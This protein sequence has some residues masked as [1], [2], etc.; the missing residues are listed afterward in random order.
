[1]AVAVFNFVFKDGIKWWKSNKSNNKIG[2]KN[3]TLT[4]DLQDMTG[5]AFPPMLRWCNIQIVYRNSLESYWW[6]CQTHTKV[7]RKW[8]PNLG[9][10]WVWVWVWMHFIVADS[11][12]SPWILWWSPAESH[13]NIYDHSAVGY[14][15][16]AH[17]IVLLYSVGNKITTTIHYTWRMM[18]SNE[19]RFRVTDPLCGN[20]PVTDEFPAKGQWRGALMFS[21]LS[22]WINGWVDNREA[23]DLRRHRAHYDVI[24][25]EFPKGVFVRLKIQARFFI[26]SLLT[27]CPE[28]N[29]FPFIC[30]ICHPWYHII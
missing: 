9:L 16:H 2:I 17:C 28:Y 11:L 7:V 13:Y 27:L 20:S 25:I 18:T 12:I 30:W 21:L 23:G 22:A 15:S 29:K 8:R 10:V 5:T 24:V 26:V 4:N 14:V 3:K 19:N 6:S 1:M